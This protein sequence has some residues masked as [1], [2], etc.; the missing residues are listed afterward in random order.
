MLDIRPTC[1]HCDANLSFDALDARICT[2]E[3]TFCATCADGLL[4]GVCPNCAGELVP[5]PIRPVAM[6]AVAPVSTA[7]VNQPVDLE[8][9]AERKATRPVDLDHPGVVIR[10]YCDAWISGDLA[11][12]V[13]CYDEHFTL[14]YFGSSPFAGSHIG[15]AALEV[16]ANVSAVA[17]RELLSIDDVMV[18]DEG[19]LVVVT[20]RLARDDELVTL[21]RSLRYRI[22]RGRL[23]EC[24]LYEHDQ[25]TVDHFWRGS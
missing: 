6:V 18:S 13:G 19:A 25:A 4:G 22:A 15:H 2:F 9:H 14:H 7:R 8:A 1:E 24:W 12:L 20:E 23:L 5:R 3:C 21:T 10:R 16:L 17:Q 11:T